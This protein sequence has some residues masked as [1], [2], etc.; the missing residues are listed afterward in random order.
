M[1]LHILDSNIFDNNGFDNNAWH[2]VTQTI[3]GLKTHEIWQLTFPQGP[4]FTAPKIIFY[5]DV[6]PGG[7]GF[8]N[9]FVIESDRERTSYLFGFISDFFQNLLNFCGYYN[10]QANINK[11]R[12][13]QEQLYELLVIFNNCCSLRLTLGWWLLINPYQRPFDYLR[14]LTDWWL[15][16]FMGAIPLVIG[17]DLSSY[18]SM[19]INGL[20]IDYF[21]DLALVLPYR[22]SDGEL[23][24]EED[25]KDLHPTI[26]NAL[27]RLGCTEV[28]IFRGLPSIW[29][30]N[31]IPNSLREYWFN[32]RPDITEFLITNYYK[33]L[34]INFLP[35][36]IL[37]D[38]L[39]KSKND[40]VSISLLNNFENMSTNLISLKSNIL[41]LDFTHLHLH[42]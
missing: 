39:E 7:D 25:F 10:H 23:L 37:K 29:T 3:S 17:V 11:L 1:E 36:K 18:I 32:K 14:T 41:S 28:R 24:T 4:P 42:L 34:G 33:E 19:Y 5:E 21:R 40:S 6:S 8:F 22:Y 26:S 38:L 30:E 2:F 20:V 27:E 13:I 15:N 9:I 12:V 16:M 35:N 31:P